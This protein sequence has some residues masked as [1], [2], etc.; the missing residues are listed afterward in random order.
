MNSHP[1]SHMPFY[2]DDF[3]SACEMFGDS[4][5]FKYLRCVWFYWSHCHCDGLPD[6]DEMLRNLCRCELTCWAR[7]KG[8]IFD[9]DKFF[10]LENGRWHQKRA[11]EEWIHATDLLRL[12]HNQT[13]AATAA[14]RRASENVTSNVTSNVTTSKPEPE[15]EPEPIPEPEPPPSRR[16][17]GFPVRIEDA[18]V[19][20]EMLGCPS[21]FAEKVWNKA[22]SRGGCDAKDVPIRSFRHYLQTEWVYEQ[23]RLNKGKMSRKGPN[24]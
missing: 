16:H 9:N 6:D 4:I 7:T 21:G 23:A 17:A 13:A 24:I 22:E 14:R 18:V 10:K 20:A 12:K 5:G 1:D 2:G 15:P 3:F 11:R 19:H 8:M